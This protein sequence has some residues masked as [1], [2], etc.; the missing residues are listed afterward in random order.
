LVSN[1]QKQFIALINMNKTHHYSTT[2]N[3]TG[4]KGGGTSSYNAYARSYS[5][6]VLGKAPILG[7][8][9]PAFLGDKNLH[10]PEDLLLASI[11]S[12]HMLWYLHLCAVANIIVLSYTDNATAVMEER[13]N[14]SGCFTAATLNPI[15]TVKDESMVDLAKSLHHKANEF[16]FIANSLNFAIKHNPT[17]I[18][19]ANS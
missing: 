7:S 1:L 19:N 17:V 10:N 8:S 13:A 18:V 14:G 16:C 12:C 3:W 9:D 6:S 11:S 4:N 5:I 2:V 15:V